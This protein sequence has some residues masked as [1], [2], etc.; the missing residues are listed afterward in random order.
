MSNNS[1]LANGTLTSGMTNITLPDV[2]ALEKWWNDY[3]FIIPILLSALTFVCLIYYI[4]VLRMNSQEYQIQ[5]ET[6]R[7]NVEASYARF[8]IRAQ[9]SKAVKERLRLLFPNL[10]AL[11]SGQA[12]LSSLTSAS[13]VASPSAEG[14]YATQTNSVSSHSSQRTS[15]GPGDATA[16]ISLSSQM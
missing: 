6:S 12:S 16:S 2:D 13:P 5:Q 1:T 11:N 9:E 14:M 4:N 15:E 10:D 8:C 3:F 7:R